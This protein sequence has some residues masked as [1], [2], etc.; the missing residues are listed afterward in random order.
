MNKHSLRGHCDKAREQLRAG[1]YNR[2]IAHCRALLMLYPRYV[3]AYTIMGEAYLAK[4]EH[5]EAANLFRRTLGAD[6]EATIPYAGLG[7]IYE[8]RGL[9]EEA[10]WQLER[11]F[12]LA[13]HNKEIRASLLDLY[14]QRDAT[15]LSKIE[16][17]RAGLARIYARGHLYPKAIGEFRDLLRKEPMRMDLRVALAEALWQDGRYEGAAIISQGVLDLAPNCLKANLILGEIWLRDKDHE[18]DGRAL[19]DQAQMLDPENAVAQSLFGDRSPLAPRIVP[20][21]PHVIGEVG[22]VETV[23]QAK[24]ATEVETTA[25]A[26]IAAEAEITAE[27]ETTAEAEIA[28]EGEIA[29]GTEPLAPHQEAPE[30]LAGLE[31]E[32]TSLDVSLPMEDILTPLEEMA[33]MLGAE[34]ET[35]PGAMIETPSYLEHWGDHTLGTSIQAGEL[36]LPGTLSKVPWEPAVEEETKDFYV[37]GSKPEVTRIENLQE[38]VMAD[39][40]NHSARLR[41]AR[42]YWQDDQLDQ[43]LE[44]YRPIAAKSSDV[45]GRVIND[46]EEIGSQHPDNLVAHELLGEA[47]TQAN[48]PQDALHIFQKLYMDLRKQ[49]AL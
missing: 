36:S 33:K 12:E 29:A 49:S 5:A 21:P 6:P 32:E 15:L 9:L 30:T 31:A 8:E 13:P 38:L 43:A 40:T 46:L 11:A 17:T 48:R 3:P 39:P 19:L 14:T 42:A 41:F 35:L 34:P 2:A 47:Y 16:L 27:S 4:G 7:L 22:E 1:K 20:V 24:I 26:E 45:L 44:E 10:I 28:A 37:A 18:A 25:E 23:A